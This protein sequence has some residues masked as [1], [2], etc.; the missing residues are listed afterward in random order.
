[1]RFT[2]QARSC[3]RAQWGLHGTDTLVGELLNNVVLLDQ[4]DSEQDRLGNREQGFE[5]E[6]ERLRNRNLCGEG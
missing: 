2:L 5:V 1:M 6:D 3:F 4:Q